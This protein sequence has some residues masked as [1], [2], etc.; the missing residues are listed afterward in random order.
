MQQGYLADRIISHTQLTGISAATGLTVPDGT[1]RIDV[2]VT[3]QAVRWKGDG[4]LPTASVG[5]PIAVGATVSFSVASPS[6]LRF[7]EQVAGAVLDVTF[8]GQ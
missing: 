6:A 8:Y 2:A 1:C 3:G 4:S 7:I 5:M